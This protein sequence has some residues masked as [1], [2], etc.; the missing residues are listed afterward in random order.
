MTIQL[1]LDGPGGV[2]TCTQHA[3]GHHITQ[4]SPCDTFKDE[5]I[6]PVD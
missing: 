3:M 4:V 6:S 5:R 1:S 2:L